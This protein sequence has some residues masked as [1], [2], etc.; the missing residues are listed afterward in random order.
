M[1]S[2]TQPCL[3][4]IDN[5]TQS[6]RALLFDLDG[7]LI[8]SSKVPLEAYFSAQ[9]GWAEQHPQYYWD[10][11]C[12]ACQELW[13]TIDFPRERIRA[14]ALTTQRATVVNL[15]AN[16]QPLRPAIVWLDQRACED[17]PAMGG[18]AER[19]IRLGGQGATLDYFRSQAE[20]NWL[21]REQPELWG[22]THK[23]LLLSGYHSFR[24]TGRYVDSV[25]AQVGFLPFDVRRFDWAAPRSWKWRALAVR[26]EQLPELVAPGGLLG[27]ISTTA[28]QE[29][30]IPA[31]LPLIAAG[32]D[33]A[34]EVIG[35]GC[36]EADSGS[37]SFGTTATFNI[38]T[39]RYIEAVRMLPPY[40]AAIPGAFNTEVIVQRGYWMVDWFRRE[41]G[42]REEQLARERGIEP[43][44]LFDELLQ[45]VPPGS[46]GLTL[47]PYWSPG[48]RVPG[49]E[50]KGAIIGFGDVHT[51][52]HIYRAIIEGLAYALREGKERVE[53]RSGVALR[54]LRVSGGG[55][56]S[57][58]AM[59]ITADVFGMNAERTHTC[60]TSGLGAAINAAVGAGLHPDH[61]TAIAR[62]SHRGKVFRPDPAKQRVYD[63]LYREVYRKMYGRLGPL[64]RS[65][66]HITGYPA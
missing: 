47:Q 4:A 20:C 50:A 30:G 63:R 1:G 26:R 33:K 12:K 46:M 25:A 38:S 9:P 45:Q 37:L 55:A 51:R 39:R 58:Q 13:R 17:L 21:A 35:S 53:Q 61:A 31:G 59:Q 6:V 32:A 22:R 14:V 11:L 24:L 65:I 44:Q 28:S 18:I 7:Q 57:D 15:D 41:F 34:C 10:S 8:A 29:T 48:L 40:P 56:Q 3:L 49:P 5:G 2:N 54:T 16:G 64:Y 52:A 27:H 43:E 36:L 42:Q 60:E 66:R 23:F 62:M 19:L